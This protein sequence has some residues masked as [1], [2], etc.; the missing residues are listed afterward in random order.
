MDRIVSD[1]AFKII[2]VIIGIILVADIVNVFVIGG[3]SIFTLIFKP[4]STVST[5]G[6]SSSSVAVA[7]GVNQVSPQ[8]SVL[9]NVTA[10][11]AIYVPTKPTPVPTVS[12]VS[13]VTPIR[14]TTDDQ[15]SLRHVQ[16]TTQTTEGQDDYVAIYS[17]DLSYSTTDIPSAVACDLKNPPLI[18]KYTISPNMTLDSIN[19]YNHTATHPGADELINVTRPSDYA[20]FTVTIYNKE[21]GQEVA[22]DGYGGVYDQF[23]QKTY[24]NRTA[25]NYLIQF[26]GAN[27]NAHVDMFIKREGN[28]I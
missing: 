7:G 6:T 1:R 18:I 5:P 13:V 9:A 12:Y 8:N 15:S 26:D 28:L 22:Q 17:D 23:A 16:P 20:W 14:T 2:V 10:N 11:Q 27:L 25:G 21:T 3:P 19:H 4:G 24:T